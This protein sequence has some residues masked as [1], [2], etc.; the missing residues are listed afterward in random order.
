MPPFK[1]PILFR[2]SLHQVGPT[3]IYTQLWI[4]LVQYN[5]FY[6]HCG[7]GWTV[8][9]KPL[10]GSHK[11]LG[12]HSLVVCSSLP[13]IH[14]HLVAWLLHSLA[15]EQASMNISSMLHV[16]RCKTLQLFL[17]TRPHNA[18][19]PLQCSCL[20]QNCSYHAWICMQHH[21]HMWHVLTISQHQPSL[22][23]FF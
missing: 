5:M 20:V 11:V 15:C 22:L 3:F 14:V 2:S 9:V 13:K 18:N 12:L 16:G 23:N 6:K 17:L 1:T 19:W 7:H 21:Y 10:L 4:F 8:L